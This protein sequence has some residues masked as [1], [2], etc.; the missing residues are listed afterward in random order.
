MVPL[1]KRLFKIK[2]T[3]FKPSGK[4]YAE[5]ELEFAVSVCIGSEGV[6]YMQD[7]FDYVR[8]V[9]ETGPLPG[10]SGKWDGPILVDCDEGYPGLIL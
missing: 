3:Y 4:Y 8:E 7:I 10:L 5:G 2:L 9:R 1:E 6:P